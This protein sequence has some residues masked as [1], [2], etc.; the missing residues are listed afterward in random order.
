MHSI[1]GCEV[2]G[3]FSLA[4]HV[5]NLTNFA[6]II[7]RE[8]AHQTKVISHVYV[9]TAVAAAAEPSLSRPSRQWAND[10]ATVAAASSVVAVAAVS[11]AVAMATFRS[12]MRY[13]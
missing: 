5:H 6:L 9:P 2:S 11:V 1:I 12:M 8:T 4:T 10:A 7:F 13:G 3:A